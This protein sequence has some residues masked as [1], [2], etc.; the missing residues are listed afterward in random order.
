MTC[1]YFWNNFSWFSVRKIRMDMA[2]PSTTITAT[3]E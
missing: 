3:T 1:V 2:D